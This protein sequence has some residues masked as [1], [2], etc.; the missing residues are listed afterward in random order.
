MLSNNIDTHSVDCEDPYKETKDVPLKKQKSQADKLKNGPWTKE[1]IHKIEEDINGQTINLQ[2]DKNN[3][4]TRKFKMKNAIIISIVIIGTI[5]FFGMA[6]FT[7]NTYQK[8]QKVESAMPNFSD[9][10]TDQNIGSY[11]EY[12]V[13]FKNG[14]AFWEKALYDNNYETLLLSDTPIYGIVKHSKNQKID[15]TSYYYVSIVYE[16][17]IWLGDR[18]LR[19]VSQLYEDHP[20]VIVKKLVHLSGDYDMEELIKMLNDLM[21]KW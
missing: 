7:Y 18:L 20:T 9:T 2:S 19:N 10:E 12:L 8:L 17:Q 4:K 3:P 11:E 5:L 6:W 16:S 1:E 13:I 14:Y 15:I 21:K